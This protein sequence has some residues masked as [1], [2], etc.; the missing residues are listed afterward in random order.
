MNLKTTQQNT[1]MIVLIIMMI[2][3]I[4]RHIITFI[5]DIGMAIGVIGDG[6]TRL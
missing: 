2:S 6:T 1:T 5:L 3:M 4:T